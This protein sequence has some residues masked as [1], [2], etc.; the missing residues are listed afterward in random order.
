MAQASGGMTVIHQPDRR[1]PQV[2][3]P[4]CQTEFVWPEYV[5]FLESLSYI[6][7]KG[8][9]KKAGSRYP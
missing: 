9:S 2:R 5:P 7:D 3:D 8:V 4:V 6:W 1:N